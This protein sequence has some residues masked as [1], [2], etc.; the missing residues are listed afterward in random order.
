MG[1]RELGFVVLLA[2]QGVSEADASA[3]ALFQSALLVAT[4]AVALLFVWLPGAMAGPRAAAEASASE[5]TSR[6]PQD[7]D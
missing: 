6:P 2:G 1:V 4:G 3:L 5:P 7:G